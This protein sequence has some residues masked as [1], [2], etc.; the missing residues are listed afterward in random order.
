MLA[1]KDMPCFLIPI[2]MTTI[3]FSLSINARA[4]EAA[5]RSAGMEI[6]QVRDLI[7]K[8]IEGHIKGDPDQIMSC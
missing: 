1:G 3:G 8:E 4:D 6:Q 5:V 2:I 7:Y